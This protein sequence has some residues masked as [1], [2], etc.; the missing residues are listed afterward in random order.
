MP[1]TAI[2]RE[3]DENEERADILGNKQNSD[4]LKWDEKEFVLLFEP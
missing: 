3:R 1:L 2:C 4:L